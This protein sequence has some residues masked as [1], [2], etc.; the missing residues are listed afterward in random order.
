MRKAKEGLEHG[1]YSSLA[2]VAGRDYAGLTVEA[3]NEAAVRGDKMAF[4]I[5]DEAGERLG[6]AIATAVNLLGCPLVVIGGGIA[7]L[8]DAF[9]QAAERAMRTRALPMVSPYISIRRSALDTFAAAW[10]AATAAIDA[11]LPGA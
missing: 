8:G 6:M 5:I 11:A 2:N 3:I 7:N 1:I 9:Y 4:H 10:G